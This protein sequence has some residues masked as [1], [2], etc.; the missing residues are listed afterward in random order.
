MHGAQGVNVEAIF[1]RRGVDAL[2]D[3]GQRELFI[4]AQPHVFGH[5]QGV[6][7]AEML[8]H[9]ADAQLACLLRVT[10]LYRLAVHQHVAFVGFDGA[11]DDFHQGGLASTVFAQHRVDFTSTHRQRDFIIRNYSR[12]PFGNTN[13]LQ[14]R[15]RLAGGG[16]CRSRVI[17]GRQLSLRMGDRLRESLSEVLTYL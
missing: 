16:H 11:V 10:H 17:H 6:E 2:G 8:K 4:L 15:R 13:E 7:Q 14:P 12:V 1:A 3:F 5:G 9:H